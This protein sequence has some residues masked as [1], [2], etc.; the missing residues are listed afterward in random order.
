MTAGET[1]AAAAGLGWARR[2]SDMGR[3]CVVRPLAEA[4]AGR[5]ALSERIILYS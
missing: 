2:A 3:I 5:R 1:A 4:E